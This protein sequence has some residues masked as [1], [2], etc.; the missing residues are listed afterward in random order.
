MLTSIV[1]LT[2]NKLEYTKQCIA[3]IRRYT[4]QENYELIVVDN[5]S[6][7]GT[8]E[9]LE[10]QQD[11]RKIYN[12]DNLGFPKGC[13]QGIEVAA[14]DNV[15]LLNNDTVVTRS[16]LRN[17]LK[18]LYSNPEV[19]AVGAITNNCSYYQ[20]IQV[21]YHSMAE[22]QKFALLNNL[23]NPAKWERRLKLV[24]FCLL[25]KKQVIDKI[26]LL[27]ERFTPG[28]FE[29]DDYSVRIRRAGYELLL[30]RDVF[31]HHFGG[32]SFQDRPAEYT[33]LLRD[34]GNK[35]KEKW[36]YLPQY[37]MIIRNEIIDLI[38]SPV[39]APLRVLEVGCACGGTLLRIKHKYPYAELHGIEF[40]ENA[41][42][43]AGFFAEVMAANIEAT[44]LPYPN[45]YFDYIIL[46]D[47]LEH[48][49]DPWQALAKLN[50]YLTPQGKILASIPNVMHFS[51]IRNLLKG[52]WTYEEAG[53][54]D[55]THLRFFTFYEIQ[56]MFTEAG[57]SAVQYSATRLNSTKQ[58]KKFIE[59]LPTDDVLK[60][61]YTVYQYLVKA[62]KEIPLQEITDQ[63]S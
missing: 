25:M 16:W 36:G 57:F 33:Q 56:K 51:V 12:K 60:D 23:S 15:L 55:K 37:S 50:H 27:D 9:W 19:G 3:S 17:L 61:Q 39:E 47:V 7:D 4:R 52:F 58:D 31:I 28:N 41:A 8:V 11:I 35:F 5:H 10:E 40:N 59:A 30:C 18:C 54:L 13:N 20:A 63:I 2:Y 42:K 26:G 45:S 34:N 21:D 38:D 44:A 53:I 48:L 49:H 1:I 32:T 46:A 22:M 6:T 29:D 43:D 62:N 14:G 24:G